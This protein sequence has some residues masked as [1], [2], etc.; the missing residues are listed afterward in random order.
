LL[1]PCR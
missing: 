1:V